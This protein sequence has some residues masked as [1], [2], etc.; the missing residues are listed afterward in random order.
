MWLIKPGEERGLGE[1]NSS[2]MVSMR[3]LLGRWSQA[4]QRDEVMTNTRHNLNHDIF[5]S[6]VHYEDN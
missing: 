5:R 2:V 4:A 1:P 6:Y 3:K